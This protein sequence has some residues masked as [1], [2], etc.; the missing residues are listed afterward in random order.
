MK[1]LPIYYQKLVNTKSIDG[2]ILVQ[3]MITGVIISI[4]TLCILQ[5]LS[6][7]YLWNHKIR[8]DIAVME[9][10]RYTRIH[11]AGRVK[12][13]F[14]NIVI[15]QFGQRLVSQGP[16]LWQWVVSRDALYR[17]LSDGDIQPL[18]GS[19]ITNVLDKRIVEYK[20][21]PF[22]MDDH[23]VVYMN[24]VVNNRIHKGKTFFIPGQGGKSQYVVDA[25]VFPD[26]IWYRGD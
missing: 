4:V 5:Y 12:H 26:Y 13:N 15:Q 2:F 7:L 1:L 10:G 14:R 16:M 21:H 3:L 23:N 8:E 11:I 6:Y 18:S 22:S 24:W 20:K 9:D 17:E 25:A 19:R